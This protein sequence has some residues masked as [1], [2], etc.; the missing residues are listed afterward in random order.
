[1]ALHLSKNGVVG[2]GSLYMQFDAMPALSHRERRTGGRQE[3]PACQD[4]AEPWSPLEMRRWRDRASASTIRR[5]LDI[6]RSAR[7]LIDGRA[8]LTGS[9]P[10][11]CA[12]VARMISRPRRYVSAACRRS[13]SRMSPRCA[14][15]APCMISTMSSCIKVLFSGSRNPVMEIVRQSSAGRK[16]PATMFG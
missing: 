1:M 7:G 12:R 5:C 8:C 3:Q 6:I 2:C 14:S 11:A 15:S 9:F 4:A 10:A 16:S 13:S